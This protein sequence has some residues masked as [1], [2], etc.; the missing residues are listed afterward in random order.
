MLVNRGL[1]QVTLVVDPEHA[2][3]I[4]HAQS[5]QNGLRKPK[6]MPPTALPNGA[7]H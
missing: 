3:V 2:V 1:A 5:A 4:E 7:G 6:S